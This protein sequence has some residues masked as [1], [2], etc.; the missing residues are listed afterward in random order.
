[1]VTPSKGLTVGYAMHDVAKSAHT[2]VITT[3]QRDIFLIDKNHSTIVYIDVQ[4][5]IHNPVLAGYRSL[6]NRSGSGR[7]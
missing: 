5:L 1:M 4:G 7:E 6:N 3:T 2:R